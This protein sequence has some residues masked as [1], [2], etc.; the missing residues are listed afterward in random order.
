[1]TSIV[2][3]E[4]GRH[5][6]LRSIADAISDAL[7]DPTPAPAGE[8]VGPTVRIALPDADP[9]RDPEGAD[10]VIALDAH[11]LARA[12]E[13]RVPMRVAWVAWLDPD[14]EDVIARADL[15]VVAHHALADAMIAIGAPRARVRVGPMV[16]PH[17]SA[18]DRV[19]ARAALG[20]D[21]DV[22]VVIVPSEV[23]GDD[24]TGMLLQLALARDGIRFL[25]DV[26]RDAQM[27][28]SLRR[29]AA[30]AAHMFA[31]GPV[32]E[33]A[34]TAADRALARVDGAELLRALAHDVAPILA[35]PRAALAMVAR[36]LAREGLATVAASEA[37][38]AVAIDE[39]C[40]R[41]AIDA[42]RA[43]LAALDPATGAQ[44][45]AALVRAA[46]DERSG[47]RLPDGLPRGLE[48]IGPPPGGSS[49]PEAP[50]P[51]GTDD[52]IERELQALRERLART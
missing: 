1:M 51:G 40:T 20:I 29:R 30:F 48:P 11:S 13:L 42:A 25:F 22:P 8:T 32:A 49:L 33:R 16:A 23:I 38:L 41:G 37:T 18:L 52:A 27:A 31:D 7:R 17:G 15:V 12:I 39:A 43:A 36:S 44:R 14:W 21:P 45:L 28:D 26:G 35:P 4:S 3:L 19:A 2:V 50:P 46:I 9:P 5:D 6:F 47:A 24:L 10:A 34:W